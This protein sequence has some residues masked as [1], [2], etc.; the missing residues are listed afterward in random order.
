MLL[1]QRFLYGG[2]WSGGELEGPLHA[3]DETSSMPAGMGI[4]AAHFLPLPDLGVGLGV[5]S[6]TTGPPKGNPRRCSI[7]SAISMSASLPCS[8]IL[9]SWHLQGIGRL[10]QSSI[11]YFGGL[12]ESL[13]SWTCPFESVGGW[14]ILP[15]LQ[16]L[17]NF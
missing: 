6:P 16:I 14:I 17:Y 7:A 9:V 5:A 1:Q 15:C 11:N 4:G 2:A 3:L 10:C 13:G 8:S 12:S